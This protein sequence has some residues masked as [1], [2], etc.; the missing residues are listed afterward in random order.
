MEKPG[1]K[2][3]GEKRG[4][5]EREGGKKF[6]CTKDSWLEGTGALPVAA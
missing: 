5:G 3:E 4:E 6:E 1:L 2:K